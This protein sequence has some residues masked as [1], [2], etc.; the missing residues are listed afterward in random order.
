LGG[1]GGGSGT[2][3]SG[4]A[5]QFPYYG[6]NGT[7]L[8]ATSSIFLLASG[9]VG[10]GTST[11]G[12]LL[13]LNG[14][15]NF[16]SA[17]STFYGNGINLS[18][19]CFSINGTCITGSA[20]GSN[21]WTLSGNN[22]YNGFG[23]NI[24]IDNTSPSY[25]LDVGGFV[26]TSGTAGGYKQ[27]GNTILY[28][29]TTNQSTLVG[30]LAG[31]ALL[32][33][34][35]VSGDT[36]VGYQA[37]VSIS[38]GG[39]DNT[40]LGLDALSNNTTGADNVAVGI[41]LVDNT[42]GSKNTAVGGLYTL[43]SNTTGGD[44][45]ALGYNALFSN[46]TGSNDSVFG[47]ALSNNTTGSNNVAVGVEASG[48]NLSATST[49]TMGYGAGFGNFITY[50]NQGGTV[51]GYQA[52]YKF[53][54]GSNYNTLLGYQSGYDMTT[55]ANNL[56]LGTE[57]TTGSGIT[58]GSNNILIGNG[59]MSGLSQTGSYQ[60]NIGNLIFGN[61]VGTGAT[62]SSGNIGIGTSSPDARLTV[63]GPDTAST[64][65]FVVANS[66]STTEFAVYDTGNAVLSGG[67]TQNSDQRLKTNVQSLDASSSLAAIDT[68]N[69]VSFNWIDGIFGGG[70]QLGFIAQA[71][72]TVF[73]QLVSTTSPTAF[74]PDGTLGLNYSG[75]IAPIIASI[76]GIAHITGDFETNLIAW[77]GNASNGIQ[78]L[79]ANNIYAVNG[80]FSALTASSTVSDTITANEKLCIGSTCITE[81]Q[82]D[83]V[84][85]LVGQS[86]STQSRSG[87]GSGS[88][89]SGDQATSTPDTPPVI[90]VN[91]DNPAI[92]QV[93]AS[94]NDLGATITGP[95]ADLN[96]GI[97]TYLNGIAMSPIQIDTSEPSTDTIDYVATDGEGN[98]SSSTRTIIVQTP[99][100]PAR[101]S[102]TTTIP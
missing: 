4:V 6:A 7:T 44:N 21:Y 61:N 12:S 55:G 32:S 33:T 94:Y 56:I 75:L 97:A 91:G 58:T 60:L 2:V 3:S 68:L 80:N 70:D 14:I 38:L 51:I 17:T 62:V 52:G 74:T 50:N 86:G 36:A 29:S 8:T 69:P 30:Y 57:Q 64:S 34:S 19:G 26:N 96:L 47:N 15:A 63:W 99:S 66:A 10:I 76:Q 77:L 16:T 82:L 95:Q 85:T 100:A 22:M 37:L 43:Y 46:T 90:S 79:F 41:S 102:L 71:V 59:V 48:Y 87:Q 25:A 54:T 1:G 39:S 88:D 20:G 101:T 27:A 83:A 9:N 42:T 28:A 18:A 67:L 31:Q 24:G 40:A 73:P 93:G 72:Q 11:P 89:G 23:T 13:S 78:D 53:Q 35:T 5:G 92:V 65:A 81:A 84:L 98:I 45:T 49:V